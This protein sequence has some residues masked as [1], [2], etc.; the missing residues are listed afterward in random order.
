MK[1]KGIFCDFMWWSGK[2][3]IIIRVCSS[4]PS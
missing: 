2:G 1:R 3:Q 4:S